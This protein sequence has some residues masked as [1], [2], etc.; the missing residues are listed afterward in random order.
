MP[1]VLFHMLALMC[2]HYQGNIALRKPLYTT[3]HPVSRTR[4]S[5]MTWCVLVHIQLC[6]RMHAH[7]TH[8]VTCV[9]QKLLWNLGN[10]TLLSGQDNSTVSQ[11]GYSAKRDRLYS[12]DGGSSGQ[13]K[14]PWLLYKDYET[15]SPDDCS[16]RTDAMIR[17]VDPSSHAC[18]I[19]T[20]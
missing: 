8:A 2:V 4:T 12:K 15:F 3:L 20:Q 13:L 16:K 1:H 18:S 17:C 19:C 14:G 6:L 10:L 7:C 9:N 5:H 11:H